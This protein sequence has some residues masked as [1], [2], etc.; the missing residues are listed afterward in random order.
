MTVHVFCFIWNK[1]H[2]S[3]PWL[4]TRFA[5][6]SKRWIVLIPGLSI[7]NPQA[8]CGFW[9]RFLA[10]QQTSQ[11]KK[12]EKPWW[13]LHISGATN[14]LYIY[15]HTYNIDI[16]ATDENCYYLGKCHH[17]KGGPPIGFASFEYGLWGI[18]FCVFCYR[19][20][21]FP[22]RRFKVQGNFLVL[23]SSTNC[24]R[25]LRH[26]LMIFVGSLESFEYP[27][28]S[29]YGIFT[30]IYHKKTINIPYMDPINY[31]SWFLWGGREQWF[32]FGDWVN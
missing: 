4:S 11:K 15:I 29:I 17:L 9:S 30:Y 16:W 32:H 12:Q 10:S 8:T 3:T 26:F 13:S 7:K 18:G 19:L 24:S 14:H 5:K 27:I 2:V 31:P 6:A 25:L 21:S 20:W 28:G 1:K 22:A 23:S